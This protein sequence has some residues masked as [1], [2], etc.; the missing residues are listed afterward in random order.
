MRIAIS[1][2]VGVGKTSIAKFLAHKLQFEIVHL[3]EIA[4]DFKL[5]DIEDLQTF[6]FDLKEC[7]EYIEEKF[8]QT[9]NSIFEGHFAHLLHPKFI[10]IVIII[11][12]ELQELTKE[13]KQR[14]Y[15]EQKIKENLEVESLNVCFYE[16]EEEGFEEKQFIVFENSGDF[17][18]EE[19]AQIL[20]NKIQ[21]KRNSLKI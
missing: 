9:Q 8:S 15:N 21:K 20:Y 3:N 14:G 11:N 7:I 1:G 13:Y 12:R 2:S 17:E 6:G 18:V 4:Q 5:E 10:D 16:A 19:V